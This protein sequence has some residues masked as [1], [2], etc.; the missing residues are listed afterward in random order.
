MVI[1]SH[2]LSITFTLFLLI[3]AI[4]NVP[5]FISLLKAFPPKKQ[6]KIILRELLIALGVMI[7]FYFIGDVLLDLINIH[8]HTV[9]ISG[10]IILFIIA[11]RMIFPD[12][13]HASIKDSQPSKQEPLI[14]PIAIPLIAGPAVLASVMLYSDDG[15][16]PLVVIPA[17]IIAWTASA[18]IL[19]AASNIQKLLGH[20]GLAACEKLMGLLLTLISVQMF[21]Q[22]LYLYSSI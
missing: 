21:L 16:S 1:D 12:T 4:G 2:F 19:L 18:A 6:R 20:R 22:G 11:I 7:C 15:E 8:R 9:L 3:D 10:G 17:L 5:I 13:S 14:I